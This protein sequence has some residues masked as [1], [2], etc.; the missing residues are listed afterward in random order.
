MVF[1]IEKNIRD[2]HEAT[3]LHY[4]AKGDNA[5]CINKLVQTL[6]SITD[7]NG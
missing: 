1:N 3:L 6:G 7:I 2:T 4:A 5:E